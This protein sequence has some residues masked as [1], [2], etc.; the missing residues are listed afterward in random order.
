[1]NI[2]LRRVNS[3]RALLAGVLAGLA[4]AIKAQYAL[5]G[6]GLAWAARRSPAH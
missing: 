2:A 3:R 1:V 6:A 4:P 5:F